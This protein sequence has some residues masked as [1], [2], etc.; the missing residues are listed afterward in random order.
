MLPEPMPVT[1]G[2][3][4]YM[5]IGVREDNSLRGLVSDADGEL[6]MMELDWPPTNCDWRFDAEKDAW[7]QIEPKPV[8]AG[9]TEGTDEGEFLG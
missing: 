5:L 4:P 9:D 8:S 6:M 3:I 2:G 7:S 1:K